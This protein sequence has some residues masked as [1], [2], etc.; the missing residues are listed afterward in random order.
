MGKIE[1]QGY[2][3]IPK[4][5]II[6]VKKALKIHIENT[7][8]EDGCLKFEVLQDKQDVTKFNVYEEFI[9]NNAFEKHQVR[10]KESD[11]GKLT[12]NFTRSYEVNENNGNK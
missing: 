12:K 10:V 6:E 11:W 4:T 2:I 3:N 1:L 9:N 8:A 5:K 7:L